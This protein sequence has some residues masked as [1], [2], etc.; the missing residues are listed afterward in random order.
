MWFLDYMY[1][2]RARRT[3]RE[4]VQSARIDDLSFCSMTSRVCI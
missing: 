2:T 4:Q 1:A 3:C